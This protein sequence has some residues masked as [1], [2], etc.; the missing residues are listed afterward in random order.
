MN[1]NCILRNLQIVS[2][3]LVLAVLTIFYGQAMGI[4]F[5]LNEA[6]IKNE[7]QHSASEVR[8]SV[9]QGDEA[10]MQAVTAKSWSYMKRS[11]LHAGGMGTTAVCLIVL[12]CWLTPSRRLLQAVSVGLGAGGFGYSIFWM[13]AGFRAPRLGGT[14][15]AKESLQWLAMPSS[16]VFVLA[17]VAVLVLLLAFALGRVQTIDA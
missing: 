12:V 17:T 1:I 3:G 14:G 15:L 13:W 5:G 7:L 16:A 8:E 11:H 9:Y 10:V 4:V 6:A 2:W